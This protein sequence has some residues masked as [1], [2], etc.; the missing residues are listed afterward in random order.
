MHKPYLIEGLKFDMRVYVLVAGV[1]P[2][3]LY[4][5]YEGLTRF[6]TERYEAPT[7]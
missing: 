5:Y 7:K 3:R 6:A 1:D 2:L 4:I